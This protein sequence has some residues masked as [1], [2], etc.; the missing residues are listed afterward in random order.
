VF[1]KA[2]L[3]HARLPARRDAIGEGRHKFASGETAADLEARPWGT[4]IGF[5]DADVR[6]GSERLERRVNPPGVRGVHDDVDGNFVV[7]G[8][9][10]EHVEAADMR[11]DQER[12]PPLGE[13]FLQ[14]FESMNLEV[15]L[16][17][18]SGPEREPIEN[19]FGEVVDVTVRID[20][21]RWTRIPRGFTELREI[22]ERGPSSLATEEREVEGDRREDSMEPAVADR[23]NAPRR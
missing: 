6:V 23:A 3:H 4:R 17:D 7:E 15:E 20:P 9:A 12:A 10:S 22:V 21:S 16:V 14:M 5:D 18:R 8:E 11:S 13:R 1:Q 2:G 19:A